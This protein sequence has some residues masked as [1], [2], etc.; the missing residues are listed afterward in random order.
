MDSFELVP[1][2]YIGINS[3]ENLIHE[4][5]AKKFKNVF[6]VCSK[7]GFES[8]A[9]KDT[10]SIL[11][12]LEIEYF[13]YQMS[14]IVA[15]SNEIFEAAILFNK[16]KSKLIIAIGS[17]T[18][19]DFAKVLSIYAPNKSVHHSVW[20]YIN[21]PNYVKSVGYPVVTIP[22]SFTTGSSSNGLSLIYNE[23]MKLAQG[24]ISFTSVPNVTIIDINY[25]KTITKK[26]L[27]ESLLYC[28]F[29]CINCI[30]SCN[31]ENNWF[32]T[33]NYN[34]GNL[35][36]IIRS[37]ISLNQDI[38]YD[39]AWKILITNSIFSGTTL[40]KY[41]TDFSYELLSIFLGI[42]GILRE[43]FSTVINQLSIYYIEAKKELDEEFRSR[44]F[45]INKKLFNKSTDD[46]SLLKQYIF[47]I[48]NLDIDRTFYVEDENQINKMIEN[49]IIQFQKNYLDVIN[50]NKEQYKKKQDDATELFVKVIYKFLKKE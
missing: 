9:L 2:L 47:S 36:S 1:K 48:L 16:K 44:V 12:T 41:H 35:I 50:I 14:S 31:N 22:L 42:N 45:N 29:D 33:E 17:N 38:N 13:I 39:E 32:W 5:K 28:V 19:I 24:V 46:L 27:K 37:I 43:K 23:E 21:D 11:R 40:N 30:L 49:A 8:K 25:L 20:H 10:I 18:A 7:S 15:D 4:L 34:Y 3:I 26:N 6:I